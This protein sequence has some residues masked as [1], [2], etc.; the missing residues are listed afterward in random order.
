MTENE[1]TAVYRFFDAGDNLIYVGITVDLMTRWRYHE[2]NADWWSKQARIEVV[3]HESR[4]TADA[5]ETEAIRTEGAL[6]NVQKRGK[7]PIRSLRVSNALWDEF[8]AA[9]AAMGLTRTDVLRQFLGWFLRE[10]GAKLPARPTT[11]QM[12]AAHRKL[13]MR[14]DVVA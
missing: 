2:K 5:E 1:R 13:G 11:E 3:W 12:D 4:A 6:R 9:A 10:P 8:G 14:P 7:T